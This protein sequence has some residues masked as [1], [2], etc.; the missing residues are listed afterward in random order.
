MIKMMTTM[1]PKYMLLRPRT[2]DAFRV[3]IAYHRH[4]IDASDTAGRGEGYD[5]INRV[6]YV[7]CY[8][9]GPLAKL[10]NA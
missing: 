2:S 6:G 8:T 3:V 1:Q 10:L 7:S 5:M 9:D 4:A